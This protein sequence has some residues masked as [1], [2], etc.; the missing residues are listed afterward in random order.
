MN[1]SQASTPQQAAR[2]AV[3]LLGGPVSAARKLQVKGGRHQTV[4]SWLRTRVPAEYCPRIERETDRRV[5]CEQLRPDVEWGV[6][7]DT[8]WTHPHGRACTDV[9]APAAFEE[10]PHAT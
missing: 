9:T 6:L 5:L 1:E 4:Q 7:R 3:A 2:R 10:T 8:D